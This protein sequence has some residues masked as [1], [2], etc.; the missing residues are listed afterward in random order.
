MDRGAMMLPNLRAEHRQSR[1]AIT[2]KRAPRLSG[3][4]HFGT[5]NTEHYCS[6]EEMAKTITAAAGL[7]RAPP[8]TRL[9]LARVFGLDP[10]DMHV[11]R[12][13]G[14]H[15][16]SASA[17]CGG[18][19]SGP[20]KI[21]VCLPS[22]SSDLPVSMEYTDHHLPANCSEIKSGIVVL[23]RNR[24]LDSEHMVLQQMYEYHCD[25]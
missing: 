22:Y 8:L 21:G 2:V 16:I 11:R 18:W 24:A 19:R 1:C 17:V 23:Y 5:V 13:V 6:L 3:L 10:T 25:V 20:S 9:D 15:M 7:S 14:S 12:C 4:N